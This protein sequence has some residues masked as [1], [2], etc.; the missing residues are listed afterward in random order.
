MNDETKPIWSHNYHALQVGDVFEIEG[1][2]KSYT[3]INR[4]HRPGGGQG[5]GEYPDAYD[6]TTEYGSFTYDGLSS[7][8]FKKIRIVGSREKLPAEDF[9]LEAVY[10]DAYL[11]EIREGERRIKEAEALQ[12]KQ[13]KIRDDAIAQMT[14]EQQEAFG[15]YKDE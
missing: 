5:M 8:V 14:K 1:D 10:T 15:F 12:A 4:A 9:H 13:K 6:I 11:A 2:D 7:H 3:V